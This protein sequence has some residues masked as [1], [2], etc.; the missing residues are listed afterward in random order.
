MDEKSIQ[1]RFEMEVNTPKFYRNTPLN[2]LK[3]AYVKFALLVGTPLFYS[4]FE[5]NKQKLLKL[6]RLLFLLQLVMLLKNQTNS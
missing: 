2:S 4:M 3:K 1:I 5:I 6:Q